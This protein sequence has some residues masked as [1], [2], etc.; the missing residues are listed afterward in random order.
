MVPKFDVGDRVFIADPGGDKVFGPRIIDEI[1]VTAAGAFYVFAG[2]GT[3]P[4]YSQFE[5]RRYPGVKCFAT[6]EEAVTAQIAS[7]RLW[8]EERIATLEKIT[9]EA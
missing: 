6:R 9:E 4:E 2:D 5:R 1:I 7:V 8:Y 3:R